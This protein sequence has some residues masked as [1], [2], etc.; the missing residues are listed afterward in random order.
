VSTNF[1]L[2][3]N[4]VND[5]PVLAPAS[6]WVVG[7]GQIVSFTNSASDVD[8]PPQIMTFSLLSFPA[9]ATLDVG[10]GFFSWRPAMAQAGTTNLIELM[11]ADSGSPILGATQSFT[12]MVSQLGQPTVTQLSLTNNQLTLVIAGDSGPDYTVQ[13]S[14]DLGAWTNLLTTNSPALPFTCTFTNVGDFQQRFFR[15]LLGP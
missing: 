5:P 9:G 15:V 1:L 4:A 2:T 13:A 3:V 12:V 6:N 11:V 8:L 14:P 7:A 10:S